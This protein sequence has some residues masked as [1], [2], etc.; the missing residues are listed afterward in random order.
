MEVRAEKVEVMKKLPL[1][2]HP[3]YTESAFCKGGGK[4][5]FCSEPENLIQR[6]GTEMIDKMAYVYLDRIYEWDRDKADTAFYAAQQSEHQRRSA[7]WYEI[8]LSEYFDKD[9]EI[10][11]IISGVQLMNG[12]PWCALGYREKE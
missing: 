5:V 2:T 11:H 7:N 12:Y 4:T 6:Y 3:H 8:F 10:V 9:V 1:N